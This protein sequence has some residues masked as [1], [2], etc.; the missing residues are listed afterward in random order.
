MGQ[1]CPADSGRR[2]LLGHVVQPQP[3]HA[4]ED[5]RNPPLGLG[6][7]QGPLGDVSLHSHVRLAGRLGMCR[8]QHTDVQG[9]HE[10][11]ADS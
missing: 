7:N 3:F 8:G 10:G 1:Y 9:H 4:F 2:R 11:L 6:T 5:G